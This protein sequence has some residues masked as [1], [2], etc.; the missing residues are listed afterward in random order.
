MKK[1]SF[2]LLILSSF[3]FAE[4]EDENIAKISEALGHVIG[5]KLEEMGVDLNQEKILQGIQDYAQGKKPPMEEDNCLNA[6]T[7]IQEKII[8]RKAQDNLEKANI[9]LKENQKNKDIVSLEKN[10]LQYKVTKTG[11]GSEINLS[12]TPLVK[13]KGSD[14]NGNEFYS[15]EEEIINFNEMIEGLKKSLIGMK[16]NE[17]R[18][19]YIHPDLAYQDQSIEPNLLLIFDIEVISK[20][21]ATETFSEDLEKKIL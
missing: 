1:F 6:L 4:Q 11:K 20:N 15:S 13:I 16:E 3:L 18:T 17:K 7:V 19:I 5:K 21:A 8:K 10:K 12:D 2:L 14:I 9:F